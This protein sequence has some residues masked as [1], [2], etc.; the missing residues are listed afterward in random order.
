MMPGAPGLPPEIQ[1]QLAAAA[2]QQQG[3]GQPPQQQGYGQPQQP[4]PGYGQPPQQQGYGQPPQQQGYGQ[5]QQGYGQPPQQQGYGQPQQGYGQA[6]GPQGYGQP[7]PGAPQGFGQPP[8]GAPQG[9]GQPAPGGYAP[10]QPGGGFAPPGQAPMQNQP[11]QPPPQASAMPKLGI[12]SLDAHGRPRLNVDVGD[13][14]PKKLVAAITSGQGFDNPRKMGIVMM[15]ISF[16]FFAINFVLLIVHF[17]YPYLFWVGGLLLSGGGFLAATGQPKA[18]PDGAKAPMWTRVGL[19]VA[20][21]FGIPLGGIAFTII[22][23]ILHG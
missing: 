20:L 5:P 21:L 19:G 12:G 9:Y 14:H 13:Y 2:G 4:P 11:G 10:P 3:Y 23:R 8:S 7:P 17:Y 16:G 15:A 6:P 1:A 22:E 18:S